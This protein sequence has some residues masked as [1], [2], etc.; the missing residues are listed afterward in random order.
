MSEISFDAQLL[1]RF[2][3]TEPE[4]FHAA[5]V[6]HLMPSGAVDLIV[7]QTE[8]DDED[9]PE[10]VNDLLQH[11]L[12]DAKERAKVALDELLE[13]GFIDKL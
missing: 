4:E 10:D 8:P 6:I 3:A 12:D 9:W 13:R 7:A 5:V 11:Y 1:L 2:L